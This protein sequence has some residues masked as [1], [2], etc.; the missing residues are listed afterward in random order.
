MTW[1]VDH[2]QRV[3][4]AV[5]VPRHPHCLAFDGD[6]TFALDIH[7]VQVLRPHIAVIDDSGD[8]QHAIRQRRLTVID[9]GNDAEIAQ[10]PRFGGSRRDFTGRVCRHLP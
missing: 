10:A 2:V 9:V 1:G 5:C 3:G 7:P 4:L 6:A 8:L